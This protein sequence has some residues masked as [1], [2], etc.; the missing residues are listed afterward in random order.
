MSLPMRL[1][2][3]VLRLIREPRMATPERAR[4]RMAEPKTPARP[5]AWLVRRH[6]VSSR[7]AEGLPVWTVAPRRRTAGRAAVYLH[8]GAY[9]TAI[10]PQHWALAGAL[11]DA[12]VRV[13]LPLYGLAPEHTYREAYPFVTA[14]HRQLLA[15][16]TADAVTLAG[17]SAGGG[18]TLGLAQTLEAP[19]CRS[20]GGWSCSPPG[21][22]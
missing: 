16:V 10:S 18:L 15:E 1:V 22:T 6:D 3:A 9:T 19:G 7:E 13:E 12:G 2:A 8:G 17:D 21:W 14:V 11:A 4:R 5:P 20:P